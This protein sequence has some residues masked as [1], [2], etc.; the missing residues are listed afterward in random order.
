MYIVLFGA[1]I[2]IVLLRRWFG[3]YSNWRE[4]MEHNRARKG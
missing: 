4:T 1:G 2:A 3:A